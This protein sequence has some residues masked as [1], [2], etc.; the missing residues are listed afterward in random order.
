MKPSAVIFIG[1]QATGKSTFFR[2]NFSDTHV[3]INLDMLKTR[4][5]ESRLISTCIETLQPFVID[6]TNPQKAD[7]ARYLSSLA[8]ADFTVI[9][10]F[11]ESRIRDSLERNATRPKVQR[12]PEVGIKGTSSRLELPSIAEGFDKLFFVKPLENGQFSVSPWIDEI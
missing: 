11:F 8:S 12:I 9:G 10:Y 4:H 7:R 2:E 5:R 3:R 6:N 1:I